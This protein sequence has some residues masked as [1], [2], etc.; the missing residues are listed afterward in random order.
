MH[1]LIYGCTRL[2]DALAP[3]LVQDGHQVTVVDTDTDQLTLLDNQTSVRTVRLAEPLLQDPLQEGGIDN[4]DAFLSLSS[5]DH[6][7]LLFCQIASHIYNV[8]KVM[9]RLSDPQLQDFYQPLA[10]RY[11]M[12]ALTS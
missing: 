10:Y 1:I 12:P 11:W 7:N 6:Q 2:T 4:T 9:C 5:N 3:V 8:P